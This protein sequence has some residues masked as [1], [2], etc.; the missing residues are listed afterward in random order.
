MKLGRALLTCGIACA[1][2][3]GAGPVLDRCD[4][5]ALPA[6]TERGARGTGPL[7][8]GAA[9]VA[10]EPPFPVTVGGYG[11]PRERAT[12]AMAPLAARAVVLR[13]GAV[14]IGV[15]N[16]DVLL[17]PD[18]LASEVRQQA[19]AFGLTDVMV[20]ATHAHTSFG[21][22]DPRLVPEV[23]ALGRFREE[24]KRALVAG[25]VQAL[26]EANARLVPARLT[27]SEGQASGLVRSRDAG[28]PAD[29]RLTRVAFA[30]SAGPL[31]QWVIF[32]AHPTTAG[33][34]PEGLDPDYPGRL[35]EAEEARGHGITLFL[36]GAVG[37]ASAVPVDGGGP[38]AFARAVEQAMPGADTAPSAAAVDDPLFLDRARFS[39]PHPDA[40]R[41]VPV[42]LRRLTEDLLCAAA[43][44][45]PGV[46]LLEL[47]PLTLV[48]VPGEPTWA[49]AEALERAAGSK[50]RVISLADGYLGYVETEERVRSG[51][52]EARRQYFGPGLL[53]A[54]VSA[55]HP[56]G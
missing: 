36:P 12:R 7:E 4:A 31:A 24:A 43:P 38:A 42:G 30:T 45:H 39:L 34:T 13:R 15:V 55:L 6:W 37:N 27:V 56:R 3:V 46:S 50:A 23:A 8:V 51:A 35:A 47:G 19:A 32:S 28:E 52:G 25:L 17:I 20:V 26:R 29:A 16:A 18:A 41:L 33:R 53:D 22:Y 5:P 44:S 54:L 14:R 11:P 48:G 49:A 1:V 9:R 10:L 40:R 21:G 2:W